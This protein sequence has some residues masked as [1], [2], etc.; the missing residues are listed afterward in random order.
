MQVKKT[1]A[2]FYQAQMQMAICK[3]DTCEFVIWSPKGMIVETIKRDI[4]LYV[5]V[6]PKLLAFHNNILMPE[7]LEMRVSRRLMPTEL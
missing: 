1:H 4:E 3:T 7:Y 2:Y 6:I 5:E